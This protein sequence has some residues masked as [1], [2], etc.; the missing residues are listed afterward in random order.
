MGNRKALFS[1]KYFRALFLRP[2]RELNGRTLPQI[3]AEATY[4]WNQTRVSRGN[5]F[6]SGT[7]TLGRAFCFDRAFPIIFALIRMAI[8]YRVLGK[9]GLRVST[10]GFGGSEIG[11]QAVA[12][13][14]VNKLLNTAL[15]AGIN[16]IDTAECY[17]N[18]E[19]LIGKAISGRRAEV[20]LMTKCGHARLRSALARAAGFAQPD[21]EPAML[22][23]SIERSLKNLRTDH[24]DVMQFHSPPLATLKDGR[25]I[26]VLHRARERGQARFVGVS[27]DSDEAV[28]AVESGA[29]DTLQISLS[30]ADQEAI[31]RVIPRAAARRMGV[32][33]KR[34][35]ANA[36]WRHGQQPPS[37]WYTQPYWDRLQLLD[38]DFLKRGVKDAVASALRFTLGTEGV[39]TAIVGTTRPESVEQNI[40]HVSAGALPPA[41]HEAIR[42]RWRAVARSDWVGQR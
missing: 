13:K 19:A 42:A 38:Y 7:R 29:F 12:Q 40:A 30:I 26:E 34:P 4:S 25:V 2:L 41:E 24:V 23:R 37:D 28:Y 39:T 27:I 20:V 6:S 35:I 9:T 1:L 16:V 14:T 32:I 18:G 31:D 17:A 11:Y 10:L 3:P 21:W 33:V 5:I 15:D 36:A 22:S 8:E